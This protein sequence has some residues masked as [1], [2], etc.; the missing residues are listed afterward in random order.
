M[1]KCLYAWIL[2]AALAMSLCGSLAGANG[3]T[4]AHVDSLL[5]VMKSVRSDTAKVNI[6]L[7]LSNAY[8]NGDMAKEFYY[9]NMALGLSGKAGFGDGKMYA[10]ELIGDCYYKIKGYNEAIA[11]LKLSL[12][13]SKKTKRTDIEAHSMHL[14]AL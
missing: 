5:L 12:V 4:I 13:E 11:H 7:A 6:L 10:E 8:M 9:A 1:Y 3:Q 2:R 14:M